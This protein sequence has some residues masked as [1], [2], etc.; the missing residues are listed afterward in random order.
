[1]MIWEIFKKE[2]VDSLRDKRTMLV[3]ILS[4]LMG[5]PFFLFI[6]SEAYSRMD[7]QNEK[8]FIRVLGAEYAPELVNY[9]QRQGFEI[10]PAATDYAQKLHSKEYTEPVLSVSKDFASQ[11]AQGMAPKVEI[12][13]DLANKDSQL[14]VRPVKLLLQGF[15][16]ERAGLNL[17][18]RGISAEVLAVLKVEERHLS[19]AQNQQNAG[20]KEMLPFMFIMTLLG[21]GMYAAIDT[22][23]GERE[24]GSLEPLMMNPVSSWHFALGKWAAVGTLTVLVLFFNVMSIFPS[25][26]LIKNEVLK[27]AFQFSFKDAFIFMAVL[28]PLALAISALQIAVA[29]NGKSHKEAQA[30]NSMLMLLAPLTLV[31]GM[32]KQ[33]ADPAWF[34]WTPL[35]AQNQLIVKILNG[36]ALRLAEIF[37]PVL[38][39]MLITLASLAY[40]ANK[41]RRVVMH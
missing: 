28:C 24:R 14:G 19:R 41:M 23:A 17:A 10:K 7:E 13:T 21:V 30:R 22:S 36:E 29:I 3:V 20:L 5:M 15:M 37:T 9:I 39:C 40:T 12:I 2:W 18:L 26:L 16:Q 38:V 33:G 27:I 31:V 4:S 8:R 34:A 25:L 11:F 32:F 6:S 35:L 1:M